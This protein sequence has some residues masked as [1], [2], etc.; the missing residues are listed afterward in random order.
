MMAYRP[1]AVGAGDVYRLPRVG[2]ILHELADAL[3]TR[4]NLGHVTRL[5]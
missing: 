1:F 2:N 3:Q 4:L 5:W